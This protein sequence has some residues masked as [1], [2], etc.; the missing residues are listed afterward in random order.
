MNSK[1]TV[2]AILLVLLSSLF[3]SCGTG[4]KLV[5]DIHLHKNLQV[6]QAPALDVTQIRKIAI[7]P[8]VSHKAVVKEERS[9]VPC[10][11]CGHPVREHK[12]YSRAGERLAEYLYEDMKKS[13]SYEIVP[14]EEVFSDPSLQEE[15]RDIR[16]FMEFGERLGADAVVV[17]EILRIEEREGTNYSVKSPASVAFRLKMVRVRDGMELYRASYDETQKPLSEEPQ[18][19]FKW[20]KV[21]FYWQTAE[22][23][24]RSGMREV[25]ESFPGM[26]KN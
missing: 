1:I 18:R 24:V 4:R 14:L 19:L 8:F 6:W 13:G 11:F 20:S 5:D 25:A 9:E 26:I 22:Q 3:L 2:Q 16:F 12:D 10:S 23:L 17:G 15:A 7:L 21:R